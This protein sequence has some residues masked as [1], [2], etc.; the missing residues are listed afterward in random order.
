MLIVALLNL[1]ILVSPHASTAASGVRPSASIPMLKVGQRHSDDAIFDALGTIKGRPPNHPFVR[2]TLLRY[3]T[4][5]M[6]P[7]SYMVNH[8]RFLIGHGEKAYHFASRALLSWQLI[9]ES[10]EW[11]RIDRRGEAVTTCAKAYGVSAINPCLYQYELIDQ[12]AARPSGREV[13]YTA[14]GYS[15]VKG[16]LLA[17]EERFTVA[18]NQTPR[19]GGP[20][21]RIFGLRKQRPANDSDSEGDGIESEKDGV[22]FEVYSYSRPSGVLG[23]LAA[24][25]VRPLQ[26]RFAADLAAKMP[27]YVAKAVKEGGD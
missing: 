2:G 18:W 26:R 12:R 21:S 7:S 19:K 5:S 23:R 16:H 20:V 15:T 13:V 6:A 27:A 1:C 17:G 22:W 4:S 11:I 14:V 10:L 9:N 25:A 24:V 8:K 3:P